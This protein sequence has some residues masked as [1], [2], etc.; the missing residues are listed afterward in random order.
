MFGITKIIRPKIAKKLNKIIVVNMT[1]RRKK[2]KRRMDLLP[3][4][5]YLL[6]NSK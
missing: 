5:I 2:P 4:V 3:S 1:E 6:Y